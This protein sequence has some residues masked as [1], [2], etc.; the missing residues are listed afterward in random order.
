MELDFC[1]TSGKKIE[2][3]HQST[4]AVSAFEIIF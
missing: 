3:L 4:E 1:P 2:L